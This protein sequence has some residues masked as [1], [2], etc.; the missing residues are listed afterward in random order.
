M[1]VF[2]DV[3]SGSVLER[4]GLQALRA[5]IGR[6]GITLF[7]CYDPD[8]LAR[9]LAHQLLLTEEFERAGVRIEFVNFEWKSTPEGRLFYSLRGAIAEYEREKIRERTMRGKLRRAEEQ[10][11][12]HNPRTF[13]YRYCAERKTFEVDPA[14]AALVREIFRWY[15][16]EDL[17]YHGITKRLNAMNIPSPEGSVWQKMTVRRILA[18]TAY[19]GVVYLHRYDTVGVKNSRRLPPGQRVQRRERP[20]EEWIPVPVPVIVDRETFEKAQEKSAHVRRR[21]SGFSRAEYLLSG[22]V[23]C[24]VCGGT[25]HGYLSTSRGS[26]RRY[27]VCTARSPGRP[28]LPKCRLPYLPADVLESLVWDRVAAWVRDPEAFEREFAE[29]AREAARPLEQAISDIE[30]QLADYAEQRKRLVDLFQRGLVP[31][32]EVQDRLKA[33]SDAV[34]ALSVRRAELVRKV[35]CLE[36]GKGHLERFAQMAAQVVD[37]LD[38]LDFRERQQVIRMLVECVTVYADTVVMDVKLPG[39][40]EKAL[41]DSRVEVSSA[42]GSVC[43]DV[44]NDAVGS[45]T[46]YD[47][48]LDGGDVEAVQ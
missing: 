26:S 31:L 28:G 33:V 36:L 44:C 39:T 10:R 48:H 12:T 43:I 17:G 46:V 40:P 18:N 47:R 4:P 14:E 30:A 45:R 32:V 38:Q 6:G 19:I 21:Y 9:N 25:V 13:G 35:S 15:V 3:A 42:D 37:Q 29:R 27:Y 20:R 16:N 1:E 24:G 22:L 34:S 41:S 8:R 5:R 11:L 2:R 7:V 23:V